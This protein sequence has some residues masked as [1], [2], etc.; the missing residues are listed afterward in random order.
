MKPIVIA[1][2]VLFGTFSLAGCGD[3]AQEG[4]CGAGLVEGVQGRVEASNTGQPVFFPDV[5]LLTELQ[6]EVSATRGDETGGFAFAPDVIPE[7]GTYLLIAESGPIR[8]PASPAPFEVSNGCS[9]FQT[10]RLETN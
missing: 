6:F 2:T 7:D 3:Q 1:L 8:G 10:V 5:T 9:T 4:V